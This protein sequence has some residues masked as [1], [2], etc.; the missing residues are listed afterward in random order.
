MPKLFLNNKQ[1]E[2]CE[3]YVTSNR[4]KEFKK[5]FMVWKLRKNLYIT[6]DPIN[7]FSII[8]SINEI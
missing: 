7:K 2:P 5:E 8:K 6:F 3:V 4:V 1:L